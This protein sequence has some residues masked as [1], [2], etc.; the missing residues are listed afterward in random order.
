MLAKVLKVVWVLSSVTV[1]IVTLF[2][3]AP[4]PEAD[5][6]IFLVYGMLFLAFPI[7]LLVAGLFAGMA[8]LQDQL[9]IPLLDLIGSNYI[10]FSVMWLA[11]FSA[12][13]VQWFVLL[14]LLWRKWKAR[15]GSGEASYK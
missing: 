14:P 2:H 12:G 7:S 6:G 5:I 13:Y 9:G 15:R 3:Y 10:G 11:F 1:L 4:G 8:L